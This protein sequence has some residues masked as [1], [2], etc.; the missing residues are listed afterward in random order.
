M[1]PQTHARVLLSLSFFYIAWPWQA[2][3]PACCA[4][5]DTSSGSPKTEAGPPMGICPIPGK[6]QQPGWHSCHNANAVPFRLQRPTRLKHMWTDYSDSDPEFPP[7]FGPAMRCALESPGLNTESKR[8]QQHAISLSSSTSAAGHLSFPRA[9]DKHT[10]APSSPPLHRF[11]FTTRTPSTGSLDR[12]RSTPPGLRV[13]S[14]AEWTAPLPVNTR[15][16]GAEAYS[17]ETANEVTNDNAPAPA[18]RLKSQRFGTRKQQREQHRSSHCSIPSNEAPQQS[19][20]D[21]DSDT[22]PGA[23]WTPDGNKQHS[24]DACS[25]QDSTA[26]SMPRSIWQPDQ[27]PGTAAQVTSPH[28]LR[29][30]FTA[31]E[32]Q[33]WKH[34]YCLLMLPV[35][36][37]LHHSHEATNASSAG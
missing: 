15:T 6:S 34:S 3:T 11:P 1:L 37:L 23:A 24:W 16:A 28:A 2:L 12:A 36:L 13:A 27:Y 35:I 32:T 30:H 5:V 31:T 20:W 18:H 29:R 26:I 7:G 19:G 21:V 4:V 14:Q 33:V 9:V 8:T 22:E 10:Q 25:Q 17:H